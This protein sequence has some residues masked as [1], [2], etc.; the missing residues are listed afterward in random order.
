M[1]IIERLTGEAEHYEQK[2]A[3]YE[4]KGFT[5]EA[6]SARSSGRCYRGRLEEAQQAQ[7]PRA[8]ERRR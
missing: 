5:E 8:W 2:A 6:R 3:E 4:A 7:E 1:G